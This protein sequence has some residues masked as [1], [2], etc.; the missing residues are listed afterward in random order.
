MERVNS[1]T[2]A[3]PSGED[4]KEF[5]EN[6]EIDGLPFVFK[7]RVKEQSKGVYLS[8][9]IPN[10][11]EEVEK[12]HKELQAP[13]GLVH[14]GEI[15]FITLDQSDVKDADVYIQRVR[16]HTQWLPEDSKYHHE[17]VHV[18]RFLMDNA[19]AYADMK[20]WKVT[21]FAYTDGRLTDADIYKWLQRKGFPSP[22]TPGELIRQP[23]SPDTNQPI[24]RF[25][26]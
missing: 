17:K 1:L 9:Y 2:N 10:W 23:R 12:I 6:V 21:A 3:T 8:L 20:G 18:G 14:D 5:V 22:M 19:L 4:V 16:S 26:K 13:W 25:L 7:G 11:K 24:T 15:G